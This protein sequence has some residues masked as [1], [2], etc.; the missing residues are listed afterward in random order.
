MNWEHSR[1]TTEQAP[2]SPPPTAHPMPGLLAAS[3][4]AT[5]GVGS[6]PGFPPTPLHSGSRFTGHQQS[7]GNKY[8]VEVIFQHVDYENCNVCGYLKIQGLTEEY[9]TLTTFFEGEIISR[10]YPFLTRKW[11][12]SEEVDRKHWGKF[13]AFTQFL[14]T[15]NSDD[16]SYEKLESSDYVFMRWKELFL[17]PDHKITDINGASFAGFYY[18]CFQKSKATIEGYY[19]HKLSEWYQSINLQHVP[20]ISVSLFQF[21]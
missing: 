4:R 7:K 6:H 12:A 18:I 17:V 8:Q 10:R 19:Y 11:D 21:H 16:F 2:P 13:S 14:K 15:F 1:D 20:E 9:P 5:E 3:S